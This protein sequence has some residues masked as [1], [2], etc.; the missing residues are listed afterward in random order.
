MTEDSFFNDNTAKTWISS[1]VWLVIII[2]IIIWH[3]N[4]EIL[5]LFWLILMC[6]K[7]ELDIDGEIENSWDSSISVC[8]CSF[9]QEALQL[10][11]IENM[12]AITNHLEYRTAQVLN[13]SKQI[14]T[15]TDQ[16]KDI[17]NGEG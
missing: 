15:F 14:E 12:K 6:L 4:F 8:Q 11:L 7:V 2:N 17:T 9:C 5:L 13:L 3:L 1:F 10:R 16:L